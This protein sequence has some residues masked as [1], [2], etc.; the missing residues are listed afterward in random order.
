MAEMTKSIEEQL[1]AIIAEIRWLDED[2][3]R[4]EEKNTNEWGEAIDEE[5]WCLYDQVEIEA[6]RMKR[7]MLSYEYMRLKKELED[8]RTSDVRKINSAE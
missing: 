8:G 4:L 7:S 1:A 2:M 3:E 5:L 6:A